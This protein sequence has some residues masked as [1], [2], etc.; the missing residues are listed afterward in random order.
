MSDISSI[1]KAIEFIEAHLTEDI[2]VSDMAEAA[3]FS[4]YHFSRTFSRVTY[5]TPYDY[6]MRR[7]L[8]E[9]ARCLLESDEKVIDIAFKYQFNAPETFSRA[10]K[11]MFHLQPRQVKLQ[12]GL[13]PRWLMPKLTPVY[14]EFLNS[15][16][17][18]KP[19]AKKISTVQ[20]AGL[21]TPINMFDTNR[22]I[23][24]LWNLLGREIEATKLEADKRDYY[25]LMM[26][27]SYYPANQCMYLAGTSISEG[28]KT[29]SS[30]VQKNI[31]TQDYACFE[32]PPQDNAAR[33]TRNYIYHTWWPKATDAPLA[34]FEIECFS[35][36]PDCH[37]SGM[38]NIIPKS[39]CI[40]F[41]IE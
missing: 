15:G 13:D 35:H 20:I 28:E 34:M 22:A 19:I 11:R 26:F 38:S 33:F 18:L 9:A 7:R 32:L 14:L 23:S 8:C 27:F 1:L 17:S 5:H 25:G 3:S 41:M 4:L 6:L 10:F 16:I 21:A 40:P 31:S 24:I 36:Q 2:T 12:Q 37:L 39:L 29:P 30:F